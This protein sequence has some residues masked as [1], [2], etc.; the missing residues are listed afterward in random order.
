MPDRAIPD[1]LLKIFNQEPVVTPEKSSEMMRLLLLIKRGIR[2]SRSI[3]SRLCVDHKY[4]L[5]LLLWAQKMEL[6]T[7][8]ARLTPTGLDYLK[9]ADSNISLPVW[10]RNLYIPN[11]W[12]TGRAIVQP[13]IEEAH[14]SLR[15]ADS[16]EVSAFT[17]GDV[18]E[19][20][21]ERSDAKTATP[22]FS[23]MS[24]LP[25]KPWEFHDTNGP[26]GSKDR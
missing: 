5:G 7:D 23:V 3:A 16:V 21:L 15:L 4:A 14:T 1:W 6:V 25:A 9:E 8:K 22:S 2:S 24:K 19:T 18:G 26:L 13:P 17:D 11:S 12:C 10:N 20:F